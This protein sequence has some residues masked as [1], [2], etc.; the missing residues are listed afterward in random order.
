[1]YIDKYIKYKNKYTNFKNIYGGSSITK[2]N[3]KSDIDTTINI[4]SDGNIEILYQKLRL[5]PTDEK[6]IYKIPFLDVLPYNTNN[7]NIYI[8]CKYEHFFTTETFTPLICILIQNRQNPCKIIL[9]PNYPFIKIKYDITNNNNLCNHKIKNIGDIIIHGIVSIIKNEYQI[10]EYNFK[11]IKVQDEKLKFILIID[12]SEFEIDSFDYIHPD[13][14]IPFDFE[15]FYDT[16]VKILNKCPE[17]S[18][19][20]KNITSSILNNLFIENADDDIELEKIRTSID[21]YS[22]YVKNKILTKL[23]SHNINKICRTDDDRQYLLTNI[24]KKM[25]TN[26]DVFIYSNIIKNFIQI[27]TLTIPIKNNPPYNLIFDTGNSNISLIAD[28]LASQLNLPRKK[29][30]PQRGIDVGGMITS[31][32]EIVQVKIKLINNTNYTIN[33]GREYKFYAYISP[34]N[35]IELLLG[36]SDNALKDFFKEGYCITYTDNKDIHDSYDITNLANLNIPDYTIASANQ[37]LTNLANNISKCLQ[38]VILEILDER[39]KLIKLSSFYKWYDIVLDITKCE[40]IDFK[41]HIYDNIQNNSM[42]KNKYNDDIN[43]NIIINI[44]RLEHILES[45]TKFVYE[46]SKNNKILHKDVIDF[47]KS[48]FN[49]I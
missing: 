43:N 21:K 31:Y 45:N 14:F 44:K 13:L 9:L 39:S 23:N 40:Y 7:E 8:R 28:D 38:I 47:I 36:Q 35:R 27:N 30:I 18:I 34:N 22:I 3:Y 46:N 5:C 10:Y 4:N 1:M 17:S 37:V 42:I 2:F 11:I 49:I 12:Q 6:E 19:L 20:L 32:T 16:E 25:N 33:D 26:N 48:V 15:N 41:M 24:V 29:T